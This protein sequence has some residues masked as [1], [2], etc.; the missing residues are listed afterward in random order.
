MSA[1]GHVEI[2]HCTRVIRWLF[3]GLKQLSKLQP[4]VNRQGYSGDGLIY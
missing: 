2:L 1:H 4:P 3:T